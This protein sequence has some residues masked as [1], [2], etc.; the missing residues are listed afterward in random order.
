M[1]STP[2]YS[3][4]SGRHLPEIFWCV[5]QLDRASGYEPEGC[6]FESCHV[7]EGVLTFTAFQR[8]CKRYES[9][10]TAVVW[11][12][13]LYRKVYEITVIVRI[14]KR[15]V[16]H[17]GELL[18]WQLHVY[19]SVKKIGPEN[20]IRAMDWGWIPRVTNVTLQADYLSEGSWWAE[21]GVTRLWLR[22]ST[23][24]MTF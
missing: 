10:V 12:P 1:G 22:S 19:K 8:P 11:L 15:F 3:T 7:N 20:Y 5:A 2:I 17:P 14:V 9:G 21:N 6:R 4:T 24:R 13:Q 16:I 23:L 18:A